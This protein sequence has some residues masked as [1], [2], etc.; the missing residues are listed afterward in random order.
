M[1]DEPTRRLIAR[2]FGAVASA[3]G[4]AGV[5]PNQLTLSGAALGLAA[6][7]CVA[8]DRPVI[9]LVVWLLSRIVDAFDG[10][11]ARATGQSS[12]MGGYLDIT[13]DM[14]AYS[15]MA[16]GFAIASPAHTVLWL[17]VLV[18]YVMAIT[19]TL[20][21]SSLL[22]RAGRRVDGNRSLQ[23]TAGLAE[24]GETTI[25]YCLLLLVP[26]WTSALLWAWIG[27]L[28]LTSVTRTLL[29][30]RLLR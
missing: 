8:T 7:V 4:R 25:L 21:L 20:A 14:L 22:E 17:L 13:L 18:G 27:L 24:G 15:A 30:W 19:T 29:A 28:A 3:I 23:F 12:L 11:V 10:L 5:T 9:A 16:V 26:G 6:A 2:Q 1:L